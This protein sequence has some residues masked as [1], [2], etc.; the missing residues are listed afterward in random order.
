MTEA[1]AA[2][3]PALVRRGL[4]LNYVTIGYNTL[5]AVVSVAAGLV[6]G[7]VA[8][9]GFGVDSAIEVTASI[10]AQWRL[11]SDLDPERRERVERVT[12]RVIGG[13]F[14][15]LAAYI[16]VES[17]T[18]LWQWEAPEPSIVGLVILVMS[19]LVMPVLAGAKRRVAR[20]LASRAL[21]ADAMQ[22]SICAYLSVIA[23]AGVALN[24]FLGWWWADPLAALAMVPIILREGLEG[25][26]GEAAC[27]DCSVS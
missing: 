16:T 6:A 2:N 21:E 11:R 14:L 17:V 22:T 9:V 27:S 12:Y 15:A 19:V 7:S 24:T 20:A 5:E 23:L 18:T 25:I 8:L 3:R 13:S 1:L 4:W 26:R 10:A